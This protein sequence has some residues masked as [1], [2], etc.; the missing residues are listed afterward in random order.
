MANY[1]IRDLAKLSGIKAHTIRI[2]EQRYSIIEPKR[3]ASNIR[4]YTDSDLK[5][6]MNIA[7][8]NRKGIRISKIAKMSKSE[9]TNEV[10]K[11]SKTEAEHTDNFQALAMA[12][13]DLDAPRIA[14]LVVRC[15]DQHGVEAAIL[16][17]LVPF[18]EKV[19]LLWLT[20]SISAMHE[21]FASCV[22]RQ[23]ILTV[24]SQIKNKTRGKQTK[25][26][27][28]LP[29]GDQQELYL[30]FVEYMLKKRNM[31]VV[32]LG[33]KIELEDLKLAIS[34]HEPDYVYTIISERHKRYVSEQYVQE[35]SK[36]IQSPKL[37]IS[38]FCHSPNK[39][40]DTPEN[41]IVLEDLTELL[42]FFDQPKA[43]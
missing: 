28:Y 24:T 23:E 25:V 26:L 8:L 18:L 17:V 15:F 39:A 6:L 11:L 33:S 12:M 20:G 5:F 35:V 16:N 22:I 9:I 36:Q 2:W 43:L 3:T 32:Y 34:V 42:G 14:E 30:L 37:L 29:E 7:F 38:G 10:G 21:Q 19:S 31:E 27:L 40:D 41:V 13:M 1:S 4:Y